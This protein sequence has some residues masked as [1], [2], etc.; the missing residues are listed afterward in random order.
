MMSPELPVGVEEF[1]ELGAAGVLI[2]I[3]DQ[4]EIHG[5]DLRATSRISLEDTTIRSD[6]QEAEHRVGLMSLLHLQSVIAIPGTDSQERLR[7]GLLSW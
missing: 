7:S 5:R 2:E 6:R 3:V 4:G 1:D